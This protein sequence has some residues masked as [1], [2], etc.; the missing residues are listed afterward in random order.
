MDVEYLIG[1]ENVCAAPMQPYS[2]DA[3]GFLA[4]W[5]GLLLAS[6]AARQYPDAATF[7]FWCRRSNLMKRKQ[8]AALED[9]R[10]GRGLVFHIAPSN[11]PVNFAFSFAFGLL[12]GNANIVRLPSADFP[13]AAILRDTCR[14]ALTG[15][16]EIAR[17]TAWVRYPAN[18]ETTARFS[19]M[20][21]GRMIWGGDQTIASVLAGG[22]KP[23]SADV[24]FAD[25]YSICLIDGEKILSADD[26]ALSSLAQSF[27]NDTWLMDQNACSSP[28][29]ILW[30]N[31]SDE[32]KERFWTAANAEAERKYRLQAASAVDKYDQ[33]CADAVGGLPIRR[34]VRMGNM[35]YRV[36][37]SALPEDICSLRG[38]CGYFYEYDLA[39]LRELSPRITEKVQTA[40]YFGLDPL[41]VRQWVLDERLRGVDR[42]V[43]IG[44]AMDIDVIWDGYD[45]VRALSRIV[46]AG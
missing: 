24:L 33:L 35:T 32:A 15:F 39:D 28:Q 45:I 30:L 19:R 40:S 20:A 29:L 5:S 38:K 18:E 10:L 11:I 42:I 13:Q 8:A 23:R 26:R 4:K 21:D 7:A 36:E 34:A 16:P 31:A 9:G 46:A 1:S 2:E 25:R 41:A 37:L 14:E 3:I 6:P 27:Y 44:K 22:G 17:R 43:P 12:A